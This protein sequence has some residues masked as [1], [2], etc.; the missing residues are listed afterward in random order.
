M[1]KYTYSMKIMQK[2]VIF[3]Q[4]TVDT[5]LTDDKLISYKQKGERL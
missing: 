3:Y 2:N 1:K 4:K 5:H